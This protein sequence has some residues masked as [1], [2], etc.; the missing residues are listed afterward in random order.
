[1]CHLLAKAARQSATLSGENGGIPYTKHLYAYLSAVAK[2]PRAT[3][4]T[5]VRASRPGSDFVG[6]GSNMNT[7]GGSSTMNTIGSGNMN[8][9]KQA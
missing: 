8:T 9:M 7:I 1:M 4:A 5:P 3:T 6:G 2:I